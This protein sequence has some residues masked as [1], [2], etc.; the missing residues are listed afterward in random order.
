MTLNDTVRLANGAPM[1]RLG[2]G[3]YKA[4]PGPEVRDAVRWA[5]EAG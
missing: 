2:P 3:V 1:P 4:K 5:L